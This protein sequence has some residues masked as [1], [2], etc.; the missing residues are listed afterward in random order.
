MTGHNDAIDFDAPRGTGQYAQ[1]L[2]NEFLGGGDDALDMTGD[3]YVEGNRFHHF[4]KDEFNLDPGNS[5]SI[6]ASSGDF[7]VIRNIFDNVQHASLVKETAYMYFLNNTVVTSQF[8]P[9]YFDLPGQ[10]S[11]PGKGALVQGSV[12][13]DTTTTFDQVLPTTDLQVSYSFLPAGDLDHVSG[14]AICSVIPTWPARRAISNYCPVRSPQEAASEEP[15][16]GRRFP[17]ESRCRASAEL[18]TNATSATSLGRR[19]RF[20]ATT[21]ISLDNG[22]LSA[23]TAIDVPI[24]LTK[25]AAGPHQLAVIGQNA[26]GVWQS[27]PTLSRRLDGQSQ[28]WRDRAD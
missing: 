21:A 2:N 23:P 12:F 18:L 13:A 15:T 5:N 9:L 27:I 4:I 25:L 1:I 8:A 6:S 19:S 28:S 24:Q 14:S 3:I 7:W 17:R 16:W 20:H 11:G 22:P 10:T 26:L